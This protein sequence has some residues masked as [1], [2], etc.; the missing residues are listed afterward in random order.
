MANLGLLPA[1]VA[2]EDLERAFRLGNE[3]VCV[4]SWEARTLT[5]TSPDGRGE[6]MGFSV[7]PFD[8][9]LIAAGGW[10]EYAERY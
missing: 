10:V 7:S 2:E 6:T 3:A 9:K 5:F 8:A 1:E 4:V